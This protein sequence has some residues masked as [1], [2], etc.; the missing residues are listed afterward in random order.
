MAELTRLEEQALIA[1]SALNLFAQ[2][3]NREGVDFAGWGLFDRAPG[4]L[5]E[6]IDSLVA[7]EFLREEDGVYS[8]TEQGEEAERE[9]DEEF[10]REV[11]DEDWRAG[12]QSKAVAEYSERVFGKNLCQTNFTDMEQLDGLIEVLELGPDDRAFDL[13]CGT[14]MISEYISDRTGANLTGLDYAAHAVR[15]GRERCRDKGDRLNFVEGD[16]NDL[17]LP[18]DSFDA[19]ISI[20]TLY[21]WPEWT[22]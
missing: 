22:C 18:E 12:A 19:I 14:G 9:P 17:D 4:E 2:K 8:L 1:V 5:E 13:G 11:Y 6:A 3:A 10:E 7:G 20:D 15:I 21:I 16:M